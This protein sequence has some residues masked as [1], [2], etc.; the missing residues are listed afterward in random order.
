ML[1]DFDPLNLAFDVIYDFKR[2]MPISKFD[3]LLETPLGAV[4]EV[5][6]RSVGD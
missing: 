2:C 1:L 6:I 5:I 3:T 4:G